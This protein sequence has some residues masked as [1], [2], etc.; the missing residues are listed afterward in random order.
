MSNPDVSKNS[1]KGS[2]SPPRSSLKTPINDSKNRSR[3]KKSTPYRKN[4]V[5]SAENSGQHKSPLLKT[6]NVISSDTFIENSP[7]SKGQSRNLA[8][9]NQTSRNKTHDGYKKMNKEPN[10]ETL[11]F[12]QLNSVKE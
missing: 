12:V 4:R 3:S 10:V 8:Q 5:D 9:N 7:Y 2:I 6:L 1:K 11:K